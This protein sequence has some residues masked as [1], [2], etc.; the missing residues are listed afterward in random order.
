MSLSERLKKV[1][2][3]SSVSKEFR[4]YTLSGAILS[5]VT[6]MLIVYLLVSEVYFNFQLTLQERV[7]VN[8]TSSRGLEIEFDIS[9]PEVPCSK[10]EIDASDPMGQ[11][12]SLHLDQYHHVW[13]HRIKMKEDGTRQLI[14]LREK[15]ELGSTLKSEQDLVEVAEEDG[16]LKSVE[17]PGGDESTGEEGKCGSCYGAGEEGECC[18]SCEDVRRA[19]KTKGWVLRDEYNTVEQCKGESAKESDGEGCNVHGVVALSTGGGNLHLAPGR[20][21]AMGGMTILDVLMQTF[22]EWNVS[23]TIHKLRFGPEYPAAVYQLDGLT[24]SI[25]DTYGMYQYYFQV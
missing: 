17:E 5:V 21:A 3:H 19:Y 12:Q 23:H 15:L 6:L 16:K 24:R 22:Q 11:P 13:K 20:G 25:Q 2:A 8:A 10:L 14:G 7:H 1:D 9:L 18:N 4:V